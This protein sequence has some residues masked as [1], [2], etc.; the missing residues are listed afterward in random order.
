MTKT[1]RVKD[2]IH[3]FDKCLGIYYFSVAFQFIVIFVAAIFFKIH[4]LK[5]GGFPTPFFYLISIALFVF[6]GWGLWQRKKLAKIV[7]LS[8]SIAWIWVS[9]FSLI[10][11]TT[12]AFEDRYFLEPY[13]PLRLLFT[14]ITISIYLIGSRIALWY[15]R[16]KQEVN[17]PNST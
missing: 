13:S 5:P 1:E 8:L 11:G 10:S 7:A 3:I 17:T 4:Y 2:V 12:P 6:L 9:V 14:G 15:L 16:K